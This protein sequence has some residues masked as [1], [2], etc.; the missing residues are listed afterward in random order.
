MCES[1]RERES[2]R[3]TRLNTFP[4]KNKELMR[5]TIKET[6]QNIYVVK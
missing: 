2:E 5:K 1:E 3:G 4:I 6:G